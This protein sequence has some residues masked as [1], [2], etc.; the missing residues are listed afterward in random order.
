MKYQVIVTRDV[1]ESTVVVVEADSESEAEDEALKAITV[2]DGDTSWEI[3][4]GSW[5]IGSPYVT[6]VTEEET[7]Q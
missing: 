1:T 5:D 3:D 7:E 6:D 2:G 4:D